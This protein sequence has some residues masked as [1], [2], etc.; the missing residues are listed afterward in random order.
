MSSRVSYQSTNTFIKAR[1]FILII[2][3]TLSTLYYQ[4]IVS[5]FKHSDPIGSLPVLYEY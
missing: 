5:S 3:Y 2:K 4:N 1:K